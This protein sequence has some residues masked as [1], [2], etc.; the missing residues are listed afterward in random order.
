[1]GKL[2]L[3]KGAGDLAS[4][5]ALRLHRCGFQIVMTE[6]AVPTTVRRTVAFSPAVYLGKSKVEEV[7]GILCQNA[8]EALQAVQQGQVAVVVD[9]HAAIREEIRP[10][11]VV[12]AIIAKRN[13]GTDVTDAPV[14]IGVGPG[15][16]AGVDCHCVV[17]TKR[18]HYLGRCIW[19]GSAIANTGVPGDIG[20]YTKE[21]I[22]R[23]SDEGIFSGCVEIGAQVQAGD[24][25]GY[26]I[27]EESG[28]KKQSP[29]YVQIEGIVRG[30]LQ[31][32]VFVTKGMKAG[33]VDP[34]CAPEHCFTVS[35]KASAIGGGVLEAIL[36]SC[37]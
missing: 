2:V 10:D 1:M 18:G 37:R 22:I 6:I 27:K 8:K 7:T 11:V 36:A 21:R 31:D 33:D 4:G 23:A 26:C 35:D 17:E 16:T 5:I 32:G 14:V 3:I 34:R 15:F 29:V 9:E 30:L 25:V 13:T 19:D 12:D 20:G 28:E 24:L